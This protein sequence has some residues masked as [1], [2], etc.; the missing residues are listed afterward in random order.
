MV[1]R[2]S[3]GSKNS[4]MDQAMGGSGSLM[5]VVPVLPINIPGL[6]VQ[7]VSQDVTEVLCLMNM[8]SIE[9]LED[10]EEFESESLRL[11]LCGAEG[12]SLLDQ[13]C[14]SNDVYCLHL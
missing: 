6:V 12:W 2:A 13:S 7:P 1:Q 3:V 5:G 14:D 11:I 10:D 4:L 8:V 9:E